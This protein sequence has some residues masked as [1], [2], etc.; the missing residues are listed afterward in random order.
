MKYTIL[1]IQILFG[2]IFLL[3]GANYF[4]HI[5]PEPPASIQAKAFLGAMSMTGYFMEFV[6]IVEIVCGALLIMRT[7]VPLALIVLAPVVV[8]IMLLHMFLNPSGIPM[9]IVIT[10]MQVFLMWAHRDYFVNLLATKAKA[11]RIRD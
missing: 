4:F 10:G 7:F 2:G 9:G 5:L 11:N 1:V 8:N 3:M 6:K